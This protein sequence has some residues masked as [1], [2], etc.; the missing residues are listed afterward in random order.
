MT[1]AVMITS[2][3]YAQDGRIAGTVGYPLPGVELR[4]VGGEERS[5]LPPGEVGEVEIAG[6]TC[7]PDTGGGPKQ[8]LRRS[9][10]TASS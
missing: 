6:R 3:R 10:R 8:L 7:A 9:V 4:V 5:E 1:E 2:N